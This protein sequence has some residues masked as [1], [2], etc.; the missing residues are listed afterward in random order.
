MMGRCG[1]D[2][3][4]RAKAPISRAASRDLQW[5]AEAQKAVDHAGVVAAVDRNACSFKPVCVRQGLVLQ[6]IVACRHNESRREPLER[7]RMERRNRGIAP[8][9]GAA[10]KVFCPVPLHPGA[11]QVVTV[12]QPR[13]GSRAY[14]YIKHRIEQHLSRQPV[15]GL[16][17]ALR[18]YSRECASRAVTG[19]RYPACSAAQA[20]RIPESPSQSRFDILQR[21][22]GYGCSGASW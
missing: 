5:V 3:T 22:G 17:G 7:G 19:N 8:I 21:C 20:L 13:V 9:H 14:D 16:T 12:R 2:S 18:D 1:S 10:A 6:Q 11:G 4:R 15:L